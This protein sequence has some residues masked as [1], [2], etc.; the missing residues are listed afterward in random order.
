MSFNRIASYDYLT[1]MFI[2]IATTVILTGCTPDEM[3][4]MSPGD[5]VSSSNQGGDG[6]VLHL[7]LAAGVEKQCTQGAH[8][9]FS[10]SSDSTKFDID[11]DTSNSADEEIYAPI[12]GVAY[13]HMNSAT[14]GFGYH[15]NIDVGDGKY[16]VIGHFSDIFVA[17]G[18]EISVGQLLG[19]EGCTGNCSGD[20][21]HVGLHEG[22]ASQDA[23]QGES[24]EVSYLA[25]DATNYGTPETISSEDFVCGLVS[26]GDPVQGHFYESALPV[27]MWHPNGTLVKTPG[28]ARV[29]MLE[30]GETRWIQDES[31]FWSLNY[32]FDELTLISD[33]E[34]DCY[35]QTASFDSETLINAVEDTSGQR[36]LVVGHD[37]DSNQYRQR[38]NETG[39]QEV[40][41]SWG[42]GSSSL[43]VSSS[44]SGSVVDGYAGLRNGTLVTEVSSSDVYAISGTDALP[45]YSW[46]VYLMMGFAQRTVMTV[47]DGL[48]RQLHSV[49][50]CSADVGCIDQDAVTTC[51]GGLDLGTGNSGGVG[52]DDDATEDDPVDDE[53]VPDEED[54]V[55]EEEDEEEEEEEGPEAGTQCEQDAC[56][57]DVDGDGLPETLAMADDLWLTSALDS[58]PAYVYAYGACFDGALS[59]SDLMYVSDG[60]YQIDF[61]NFW[62]DCVADLSLI[63]SMG[64]DG[65]APQS[66]M[67]NWYWWQGTDFCSGGSSLC[68]LQDNGTSWEEWLISV[69][70]DP[71]TGLESAGNG[72]TSNGQL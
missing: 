65:G 8:G 58:M 71:V 21:V 57:L 59:M 15:V 49:G 33:E 51:G 67:S 60:Y 53:D 48:V 56:I 30:D 16:A 24:I 39:W 42:L 70:W 44:V 25:A 7:P 17:N 4:P 28:N 11:L 23:A 40:L 10:H 26:E 37:G 47:E 61:S 9:T 5:E 69:S 50:S 18:Q 2:A 46:D 12:G 38:V 3:F 27:P 13:V 35:G 66:N 68:D 36:W 34:L 41:A 72:F 32:D 55:D 1:M 19:Y 29:Y 52:D 31:V 54:P 45:I 64:T 63:S 43:S 62:G 20:H 14:S 22:N 6:I